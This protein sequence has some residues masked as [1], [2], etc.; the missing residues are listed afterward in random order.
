[1]IRSFKDKFT[2]ALYHGSNSGKGKSFP[3][4]LIKPAQ[5]KL[6]RIHSAADL[7]DLKVPPGN[8]MEKLKGNL[9]GWYSMRINDQFRIIFQW[10][11]GDAYNVSIVDYH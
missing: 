5:R 2:E 9:E 1:M 11:N 10:N 6:D 8:R 4:E 7:I 3:P